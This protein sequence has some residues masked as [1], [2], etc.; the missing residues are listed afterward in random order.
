LS[1]YDMD[2][3]S[4]FAYKNAGSGITEDSYA[5]LSHLPALKRHGVEVPSYKVA[6]R[7]AQNVSGI[8][9]VEY[10]CCI[11]SCC[12]Y[13]GP[14][15]DKTQCPYCNEKRLDSKTGSPRRQFRYL[16]IIPRLRGMY[17]NS[18]LSKKMLYRHTSVQE[19]REGARDTVADLM[20][21]THYEGLQQQHVVVDGKEY[22]HKFF[23]N[24]HDVAL[25]LST[26]GFAPFRR[27]SKTC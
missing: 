3:L 22:R 11:N 10:D 24:P 4:F 8:K 16:P 23:D 19:K 20:D 12:C 14:L 13:A 27:R 15:K 18:E 21:G 6:K 26:D 5:M 17:R 7:H 9:P 1:D 25:G 2:T